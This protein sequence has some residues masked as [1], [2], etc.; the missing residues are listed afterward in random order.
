MEEIFGLAAKEVR[1]NHFAELLGGGV[2]LTGGSSLMAGMPEL[3]EQVF[4]MPVRLGLPQGLGGLVR[5]RCRP[6]L[7]RPAWAWCCT[8]ARAETQPAGGCGRGRQ[9]ALLPL[10]SSPL[11]LAICSRIHPSTGRAGST[12]TRTGSAPCSNSRSTGTDAA[13]LKVVGVGGAGGNAINRMIGAGLRGVEFIVANT[14][15]QALTQSLA[16]TRVQIG[17]EHDPRPGFGR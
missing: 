14:D 13:K 4:E 1:K 10:R 8:R 7:S 15:I 6:A 16:P 17:V 3:A 5:Q 9:Q 12:A 11:V 2:V